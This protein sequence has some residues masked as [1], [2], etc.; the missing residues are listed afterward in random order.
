[1]N[2]L[3]G[4]GKV[5]ASTF[6]SDSNV[7]ILDAGGDLLLSGTTSDAVEA[8]LN[9]FLRRG[10]KLITSVGLVGKT[11]VAA[12][13]VPPKETGIDTTQTLNL[14]DVVK[15]VDSQGKRMLSGASSAVV[16]TSLHSFVD[17]GSKVLTALHQV[18]NSWVA[19]CTIPPDTARFAAGMGTEEGDDGCRVEEFGFK[20][21]IY[22]S[23]QLA[24]QLRVEK[25]KSSGA[26]IIGDVEQDGQEWTAVCDIGG[27]QQSS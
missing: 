23:S 13:T 10:S 25:M 24:V 20:R 2:I 17:L 4:D 12:C 27:R 9:T 18:G 16:E 7:K 11:W 26:E 1:M 14:S 6:S 15:I 8:C 19:A 5:K 22:G 21:I 3:D